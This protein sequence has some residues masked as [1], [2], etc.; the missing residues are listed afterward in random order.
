MPSKLH[1][2][3]IVLENG[4]LE[5]RANKVS[6]AAAHDFDATF[7]TLFSLHDKSLA[8]FRVNLSEEKISNTYS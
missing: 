3:A 6:K 4:H 1:F 8:S 7:F 2:C 5:S